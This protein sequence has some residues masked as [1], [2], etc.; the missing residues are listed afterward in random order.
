MRHAHHMQLKA[1]DSG[2]H[3]AAAPPPDSLPSVAGRVPQTDE[4]VAIL[5]VN[6]PTMPAPSNPRSFYAKTWDGNEGLLQKL[7]EQ[8]ERKGCWEVGATSS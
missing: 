3:A 4:V 6:L 1:S 7:E 8:G 5:S 2:P